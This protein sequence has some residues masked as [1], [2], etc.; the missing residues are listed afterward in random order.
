MIALRDADDQSALQHIKAKLGDVGI[1][2]R[3]SL[4]ETK[5][6]SCLGGRASD[7]T[8]VPFSFFFCFSVWG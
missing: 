6:I 4:E 5:I 7:L 2:V 1:D 8:A 3:F